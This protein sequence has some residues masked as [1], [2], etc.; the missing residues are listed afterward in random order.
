MRFLKLAFLFLVAAEAPAHALC[1]NC[2]GQSPG[3]SPAMRLVGLFL[4]VPPIVFFA[5]SI[6]IRRLSE[7]STGRNGG[8]EDLKDPDPDPS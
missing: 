7:S 8:T 6:A 4:L 1:P 5:V 2:L 3:I